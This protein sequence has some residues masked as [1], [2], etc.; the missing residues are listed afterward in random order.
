MNSKTPLK[1]V[2][3]H[4]QRAAIKGFDSSVTF[5]ALNILHQTLRSRGNRPIPY[6]DYNMKEFDGS[7]RMQQLASHLKTACTD[8]IHFNHHFFG[9]SSRQLG[10]IGYKDA[11]LIEKQFDKINQLLDERKNGVTIKPLEFNT[12]V[13]GG[14]H[15]F[16]ERYH[17]F[18]GFDTHEEFRE[19]LSTLMEWQVEQNDG[20][21]QMGVRQT[22]E[23]VE[24]E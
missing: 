11:E 21:A 5:N 9:L 19:H 13:Y 17:V 12:A 18:K 6:D 8:D 4:Y 24:I 2:L 1:D 15:G 10:K 3:Y 20:L 22:D 23:V 16:K 14:Y 7:W